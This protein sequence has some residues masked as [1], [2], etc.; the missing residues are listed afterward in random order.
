MAEVEP[1]T[2]KQSIWYQ[3]EDFREI[4]RDIEA[5]LLELVQIEEDM[6]Y[7]DTSK[8]TL[9]GLEQRFSRRFRA[10]RRFLQKNTVRTVL[11]AQKEYGHKGEEAQRMIERLSRMCSKASRTR[12]LEVG[13]LDQFAA[14]LGRPLAS[15]AVDARPSMCAKEILPPR[16][17]NDATDEQ[18]MMI[19]QQA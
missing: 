9:R 14:G 5:T 18:P 3:P 10:Q 6:R 4:R 17:V 19:A 16:D 11:T 8:Y 13:A 15:S 1:V 2:D 7:W 12:A